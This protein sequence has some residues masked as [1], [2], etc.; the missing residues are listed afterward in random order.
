LRISLTATPSQAR[1]APILVRDKVAKAFALANELGYDGVELHL[2]QPGD[3]DRAAVQSMMAQYGLGVPMIGT[4][5][6]A[7]EDGLTFTDPNETVRRRA[8]ERMAGHIELAE[9]LHAT[10]AIG[11]IKGQLGRDP[12]ERARKRAWMLTCIAQCCELAAAPGVDLVLEPINRYEVDNL[13]SV[14]QVLEVVQEVAQPNLKLL[15]D[16]FHMNI[17]EVDIL[18]SLRQAGSRIGHVHL[19]DSNRQAPGHGHLDVRG[20]LATLHDM[21]YPGYVSLEVLPLPTAQEAA[22]DGIRTVRNLL[23]SL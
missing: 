14:Q 3:V 10:V 18:A 20:V 13:H 6:A 23:S 21:G 16:T 8:V 15:V 7:A 19:V 22:A 5:M 1:F 9:A 12:E 17:E 11:L 2:R 4:G